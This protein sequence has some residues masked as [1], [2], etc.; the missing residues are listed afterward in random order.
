[1]P[2]Q[3]SYKKQ[4][5]LGIMLLL[6]LLVAIEIPARA[7]EYYNP[8]CGLVVNPVFDDIDYDFKK[9]ICDAWESQI[10]YLDPETKIA[11]LE[12]NQHTLTM[13]INSHGFRG[14][15]IS[16]EKLD[17]VY[18][19]FMV[20]GSTTFALRS[21]SDQ[22]TI[23]GYLQENFDQLNL[24]KNIQV[25]NAGI[26]GI[27]S[28]DEVQLIKTKILKFEPDLIIIYDGINDIR[29]PPG[30]TKYKIQENKT[31]E[32]IFDDISRKYFSFYKTPKVMNMLFSVEK[33]SF[34]P[35]LT[36]NGDGTK[37]TI[38]KDNMYK[39]C[40]LGKQEGFQT[41]IVLQPFLGTGNKVL[42]DFEKKRLENLMT[43]DVFIEYQLF[44]EKMREL[45][46]ICDKTLDARNVFDHIQESVYFDRA[47]VHYKFNKVVADNLY[48]N[49]VGDFI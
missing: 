42:T 41:M 44:E 3:V 49:I 5:V 39:I 17:D 7:Y 40:E 26:P 27:T 15:E 18:R 25:V 34:N 37:A 47:H 10:N 36:G 30:N 9:R 12:P 24:E 11:S 32:R 21:I 33:N 4:F 22:T 2:V 45:D 13:N 29:L 20:G 14:E 6:V 16:K 43:P 46:N 31:L 28:T 48:E 23:P 19:I 8:N 35:K 1:V 38:W